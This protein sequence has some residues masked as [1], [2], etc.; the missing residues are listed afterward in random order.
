VQRG[1]LRFYGV[2]RRKDRRGDDCDRAYR[3]VQSVQ[4]IF[5]LFRPR[6][7][8][9]SPAA[10]ERETRRRARARAAGERAA[11]G[12]M[13]RDTKFAADDHRNFNRVGQAF[14]A[15]ETFSGLET[16][17]DDAFAA[18]QELKELVPRA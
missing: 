9:V 17:L 11:L 6:P 13:T 3:N 8:E 7:A 2:E 18:V 5:N 4:I 15:G 14:D 12:E 16:H 1:K 10:R